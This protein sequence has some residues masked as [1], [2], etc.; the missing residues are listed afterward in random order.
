MAVTP[1]PWSTVWLAL[2]QED[3]PQNQL[4]YLFAGTC[5]VMDAF[6][7]GKDLIALAAGLR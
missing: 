1:F 7:R 5:A 3:I 6:P 2:L 4:T